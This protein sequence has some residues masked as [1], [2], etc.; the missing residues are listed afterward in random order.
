MVKIYKRIRELLTEKGY[1]NTGIFI[2]NRLFLKIS[3]NNIRIYRYYFVAQPVK[4]RPYLP[5]SRGKNIVIREINTTDPIRQYF[6]RPPAVI[7]ARFKNGA[8]CLTASKE[9]KFVGFI[10]LMFGP[11]QEDEVRARFIPHPREKAVWDFDVY[12]APDHRVGF[13]F[14]RLWDEANQML[15]EKGVQWSFSRI[16]ALNTKSLN[17]HTGFGLKIIG[18]AIFLCIGSWQ[19]TLS[20]LS[21]Y[22]HL[23]LKPDS[24]PIF[25]LKTSE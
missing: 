1:F 16:S 18:H 9:E 11:Y 4:D 7:D 8:V 24:F 23:S 2:L 17:S 13:T 5:L 19:L 14:L 22:I 12:V 6:P 20:S 3:G 15:R 21:P 10:W 25:N